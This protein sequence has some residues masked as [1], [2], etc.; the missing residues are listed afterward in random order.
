MRQCKLPKFHQDACL[1]LNSGP[2]DLLGQTFS[3]DGTE[4]ERPR[5]GREV[6]QKEIGK[7]HERNLEQELDKLKEGRDLKLQMVRGRSLSQRQGRDTKIVK[8]VLMYFL[9]FFTLGK[10]RSRVITYN[11]FSEV[12]T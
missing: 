4:G 10:D 5:H 8:R 12:W 11:I 7:E 9:V 6:K 2:R 3:R 1:T